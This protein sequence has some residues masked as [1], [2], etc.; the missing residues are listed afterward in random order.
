V[1]CAV[2]IAMPDLRRRR[3]AGIAASHTAAR[4]QDLN[5]N[6]CGRDT[7]IRACRRAIAAIII[8]TPRVT[9]SVIGASRIVVS[10]I[11]TSK[12]AMSIKGPAKSKTTI[13][14]PKAMGESKAT[15]MAASAE[16][17]STVSAMPAARLRDSG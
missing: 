7:D 1:P 3:V 12:I 6:W 10:I 16:A 11:A 2:L 5:D 17:T 13:A 4:W 15:A 8:P 9:V 14:E